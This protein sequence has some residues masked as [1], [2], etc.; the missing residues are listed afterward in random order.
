MLPRGEAKRLLLLLSPL[1]SSGRVALVLFAA[2]FV[3]C[4][5]S[6]QLD[7]M[8]LR[9]N[10]KEALSV[11]NEARLLAQRIDEGRVTDHYRRGHADYLGHQ[12]EQLLEKLR[13]AIAPPGR[14]EDLATLREQVRTSRGAIEDLATAAGARMH[15]VENELE[16]SATALAPLASRP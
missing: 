3:A 4:S 16:H 6:K 15:Q 5:R 14:E 9:S 12:L 2:A 11:A 7:D 13:T 10:A 8:D 1:T